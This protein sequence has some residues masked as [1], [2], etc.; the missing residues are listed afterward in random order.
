MDVMRDVIET[1]SVKVKE[2]KG[3]DK[4]PATVAA[5]VAAAVALV[6][7]S[8]PISGSAKWKENKFND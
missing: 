2:S 4:I 1:F 3:N 5:A 6:K 7:C 8:T